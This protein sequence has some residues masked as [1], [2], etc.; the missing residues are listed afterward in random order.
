MKWHE[1]KKRIDNIIT[2]DLDI[3]RLRIACDD[4]GNVFLS[5]EGK[6]VR[7]E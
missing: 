5:V 4:N 3:M 2:Q 7:K 1:L 6:E